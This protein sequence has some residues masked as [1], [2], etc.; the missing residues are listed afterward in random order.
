MLAMVGAKVAPPTS[1]TFNGLHV[2]LYPRV[3]W[4][5]AWAQT[6]SDL[7]RHVTG[8]ADACIGPQAVLAIDGKNVQLK[9]SP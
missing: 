7:R 2:Q 9:V 3:S 1:A 5:P 8:G 4:S 6:F